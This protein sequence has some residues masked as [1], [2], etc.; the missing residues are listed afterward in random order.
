MML[1]DKEK[2]LLFTTAGGIYIYNDTKMISKFRFN[3]SD[4]SSVALAPSRKYLAVS[5][6]INHNVALIDLSRC[7]SIVD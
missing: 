3:L 2:Y 6:E 1:L 7:L 5:S 4:V